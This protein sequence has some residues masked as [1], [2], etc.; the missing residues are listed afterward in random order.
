MAEFQALQNLTPFS[1]LCTWHYPEFPQM[2]FVFLHPY[3]SAYSASSAYNAFQNWPVQRLSKRTCHSFAPSPMAAPMSLQDPSNGAFAH[4]IFPV[5]LPFLFPGFSKALDL[6]SAPLP[7]N[8][9]SPVADTWLSV[10]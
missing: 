9:H 6:C 5:S 7:P 2:F 1:F 3:A 8:P 4:V 10:K